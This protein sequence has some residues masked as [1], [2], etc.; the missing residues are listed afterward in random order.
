M[1]TAIG[2]EA[3]NIGEVFQGVTYKLTRAYVDTP[4]LYKGTAIPYSRMVT[5]ALV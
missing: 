5:T 4:P 3:N 2:V 1:N